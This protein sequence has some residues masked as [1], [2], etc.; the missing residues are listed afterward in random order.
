MDRDLDIS[1]HTDDARLAERV[2]PSGRRA[3]E[4]ERVERDEPS[5][6]SPYNLAEG[7]WAAVGGDDLRAGNQLA[8]RSPA[9]GLEKHIVGDHRDHAD[10]LIRPSPWRNSAAQEYP[11]EGKYPS[12]DCRKCDHPHI[13]HE[14]VEEALG[15]R[16]EPHLGG[17]AHG[18]AGFNGSRRRSVRIQGGHRL[19]ASIRPIE[20]AVN[21]R[22]LTGPQPARATELDRSILPFH[23]ATTRGCFSACSA[24]T[25]HRR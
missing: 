3:E 14:Q 1:T 16:R 21:D 24:R 11:C 25:A 15:A 20:K 8:E 10:E 6:R 4:R 22:L 5:E 13:V 18:R 2:V 9:Q 19:R 17:G 23:R 12:G 7:C